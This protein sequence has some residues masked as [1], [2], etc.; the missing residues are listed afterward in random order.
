[1]YAGDDRIGFEA[2]SNYESHT[3][4]EVS[5]S[6]ALLGK[7]DLA[8]NPGL[9]YEPLAM[10]T[11]GSVYAAIY[12]DSYFDGWAALNRSQKTWDKITGY[13]KG[14]IIGS[15]GENPVFSHCEGAW[16]VLQFVPAGMLRAEKIKSKTAALV[17]RR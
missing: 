17:S 5:Y 6:G 9:V 3:W 1:M 13:P 4:I 15:D 12:K 11:G 16:T 8:P 10:T 2:L 7:Y 14:R